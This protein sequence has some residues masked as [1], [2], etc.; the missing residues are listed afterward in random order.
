MKKLRI[1]IDKISYKAPFDFIKQPLSA[2]YKSLYS[3]GMVTFSNTKSI[4]KS[5][6]PATAWVIRDKVIF[7]RDKMLIPLKV[8][9]VSYPEDDE[10]F[11]RHLDDVNNFLVS[12]NGSINA[13]F[14]E[15]IQAGSVS[16][17]TDY[18]H[19]INNNFY[20]SAKNS[21]WIETYNTLE[22]SFLKDMEE[23]L[24]EGEG[25]NS[26]FVYSTSYILLSKQKSSKLKEVE[27]G[28]KDLIRAKNNLI[29]NRHLFTTE[30]L[31]TAE[32]EQYAINTFNQLS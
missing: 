23:I 13:T 14:S 15:N 11:I 3:W 21:Q 22:N 28:I 26:K 4:T 10:N 6:L 24:T 32:L 12:F 29:D 5:E 18:K 2:I 25:V 20:K 16:F 8:V 30:E 19:K 9:F 27:Q 7:T 17:A 1:A 31:T